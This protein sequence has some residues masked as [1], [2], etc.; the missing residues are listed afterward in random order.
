MKIT[1]DTNAY[2]SAACSRRQ[3]AKWAQTHIP[4]V[5]RRKLRVESLR[6]VRTNE[7]DRFSK[8]FLKHP[9]A[10]IVLKY[11]SRVTIIY[12]DQQTS[13]SIHELEMTHKSTELRF[14][15]M[16]IGLLHS[17]FNRIFFHHVRLTKI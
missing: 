14:P 5:I 17:L 11:H 15:K 13:I 8:K 3:I 2:S 4:F 12:M 16:I 6:R 9:C 10:I 7:R 1:I